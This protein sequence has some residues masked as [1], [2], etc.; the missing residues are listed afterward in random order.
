M[1]KNDKRAEIFMLFILCGLVG[2]LVEPQLI[3]GKV[4]TTIVWWIA[5]VSVDVVTEKKMVK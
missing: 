1:Y 4:Q 3:L 2:T 5:I